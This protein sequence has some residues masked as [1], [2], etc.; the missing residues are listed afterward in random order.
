MEIRINE[1]KGSLAGKTGKG[2]N[3][4]DKGERED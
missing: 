4:T 2:V 1:E 3:K